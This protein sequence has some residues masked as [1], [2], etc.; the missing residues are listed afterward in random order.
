MDSVPAAISISRAEVAGARFNYVGS[1]RAISPRAR[2]SS[3]TD[4]HIA[5]SKHSSCTT[6]F[7]EGATSLLQGHRKSQVY[8]TGAKTKL[9]KVTSSLEGVGPSLE[10]CVQRKMPLFHEGKFGPPLRILPIGGLGE[11]GMNCMLVGH[12]DRYIMIDAGLMFPDS[13]DDLGVQKILPDTEFIRLWRDKIEAVIFTH[14]HEDH[15][16]ALPWVIPV[17]DPKTP[18]YSTGFTMELIKRR[19]REYKINFE[20]RCEVFKMREKFTAGPFEIEAIRVTHSIP[21]CCGLILRCQ[22]GTIFHTGDWKIDENPVDGNIFDR[23]RLEELS[24]EGVTLM[25]SDSTNV[26][27][28]G[29]TTSESDVAAALMRH[30][31]EAKAR[32]ITTQFAS[33]V[34]RLGSVKAAADACGRKLVFVGTSL[35]TYFEAAWR[36][37]QAPFHPTCLIKSDDIC[38]YAPKDLLIVTTGSQAEPRA[39]LNLASFGSSRALKLTKDDI[40]LYSAKMIPGNETRVIKMMNRIAELGPKIV[41]GKQENLHTSGH[42]YR[43]ELEEVLKLVKPQHFLPVHGE[44]AYL[45][46]HEVIGKSAGIRHTTVIK[47]GEMLGVSPLR[48]G[49]VLSNGFAPLGKAEMKLMYNDGGKAF[50]TATDLRIE[51]RMQLALE[52]IIFVSVE[53]CRDVPDD[54]DEVS[55]I[56]NA[57]P[58]EFG[59]RGRIRITTRCLWLDGGKLVEALQRAANAA[60]ASCRRDAALFTVELTVSRMLRKI[61]QKYSNKRPEVIVIATE[62]TRSRRNVSSLS[63]VSTAGRSQVKNVA[64]K[65][66]DEVI[67]DRDMLTEDI[68][69]EVVITT[70]IQSESSDLIPVPSASSCIRGDTIN[71]DLEKITESVDSKSSQMKK[72]RWKPSEIVKLIEL[73]SQM[74]CEFEKAKIKKPLWETISSHLSNSGHERNYGQCKSMWVSLVTK[75]ETILEEK[76]A[77]KTNKAWPYFEAMHE[78]LSTRKNESLFL[79]DQMMQ[80]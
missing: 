33:N 41:M 62:S 48:N 54:S 5:R 20:K 69:A 71:D 29:R 47:N 16:G 51:E 72:N 38:N 49:R 15:I 8:R 63:G 7:G 68:A 66:I 9:G 56:A 42:G 28:A 25:M 75:Y 61:V 45:K 44:F 73:R 57:V 50:G 24:K 4:A 65:P 14:G 70:A 23:V 17:L 26:L 6:A 37:G 67:P 32:V 21:D 78:A 34:H 12:Y 74:E 77:G 3:A 19:L 22:D 10:D 1:R 59:L 13:Y 52:G 58:F 43:E 76:S 36:D 2:S 80:S 11:I 18:I 64:K 27:S 35:R 30:V 39:A 40:I 79:E 46:E 60:V 53:V 31:A 55:E